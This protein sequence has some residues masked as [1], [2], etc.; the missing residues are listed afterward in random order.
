MTGGSTSQNLLNWGAKYGPG[1]AEG[2][3]WRLVLPMFLHVGFFHMLTNLFGLVIFGS[4]VER[5]FGARDFVVIYVISGIMGNV[6]S[7][8]AGPNLGAGA[9]GA[10]MG[11]LGAFG[12]Y[13]FLNRAVLGKYGRDYLGV[14]VIIVVI[15]FVTGLGT[16][17][18]GFIGLN[19][20]R[21]DNAAHLGGL[22][23]GVLIAALI[24]PRER[25][26]TIATPFNFGAP[27]TALR[28]ASQ[29]R[30]RL[31]IAIV[32]MMTISV[33]ITWFESGTYVTNIFGDKIP[34]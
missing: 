16:Q 8:L 2:Q 21:T 32:L 28:M 17:F 9:S 19:L 14:L 24:A 5:A 33:A 26:F 34:G 4:K 7:F 3:Y 1:I 20:P 13:L 29:P 27:R 15:T 30:S 6:I 25:R 31:V 18:L 12:L 10:V 11:I 22:I 23:A